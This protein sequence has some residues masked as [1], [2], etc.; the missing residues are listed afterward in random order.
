MSSS[1]SYSSSSS[2]LSSSSSCY[3]FNGGG[4][5]GRRAG[6]ICD[7]TL[8]H[9]RQTIT[10]HFDPV[11]QFYCTSSDFIMSFNVALSLTRA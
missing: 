5:G 10:W 11:V 3:G 6:P 8:L 9:V 2:S 4:G 1:S 7:I